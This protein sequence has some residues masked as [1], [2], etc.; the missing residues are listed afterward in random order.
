L[1]FTT[2]V[3]GRNT[4]SDFLGSNPLTRDR[5]RL[6]SAGVYYDRLDP[7]NGSHALRMELEKGIDILGASKKGDADL[8]RIEATLDFI[9]LKLDY[10]QQRKLDQDWLVVAQISGQKSSKPL[11]SALQFGY[12]GQTFGRAYN[13]SEITGDDGVAAMAELRYDDLKL[14]QNARLSPYAFYDIGKVWN[15][16]TNGETLSAS[17]AGFGIR[18]AYDS[19]VS[20]NMGLAWPLTREASNPIYGENAKDP[21]FFFSLGYQF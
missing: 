13:P 15:Q 19:G 18:T 8:S 9:V 14:W 11:F 6:I 16:A 4:N 20:S 12:G 21:R 5:I 1:S 2:E 10:Q 17:S 7:W 3:R